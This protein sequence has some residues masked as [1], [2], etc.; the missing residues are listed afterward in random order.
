[1]L[2]AADLQARGAQVSAALAGGSELHITDSG[3]TDL[4]V[5]VQGRK[6]GVSDGIITADDAKTAAGQ[7]V[8]LPAGEVYV[9]PVPG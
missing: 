9:A 8:Y 7:S 3:G 1:M 5:R 4:K 6:Y 2:A